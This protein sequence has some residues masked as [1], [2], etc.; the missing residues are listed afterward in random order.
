M[1]NFPPLPIKR[2][3]FRYVKF[4]RCERHRGWAEVLRIEGK[5]FLARNGR[6]ML[7]EFYVC[8]NQRAPRDRPKKMHFG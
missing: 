5:E 2:I 7:H 1:L 3:E 8:L 4:A 6:L